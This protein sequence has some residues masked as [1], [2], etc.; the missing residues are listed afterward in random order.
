MAGGR[1]YTIVEVLYPYSAAEPNQISLHPHEKITVLEKDKS[2][3]WIGKR[4]NDDVGIFPSTYV[5]VVEDRLKF[6]RPKELKQL[7]LSSGSAQA[8][9]ARR[10]S[11]DDK[12]K[13]WRH[14]LGLDSD[15]DADTDAKDGKEPEKL[16]KARAEVA[17][18]RKHLDVVS[19][20]NTKL[21][22]YGL[23]LE[24]EKEQLAAET[25]TIRQ[26]LPVLKKQLAAAHE[27]ERRLVLELDDWKSMS[28]SGSER[29]PPR[30]YRDEPDA[31]LE[32]WLEAAV[33]DRL[34]D[35]TDAISMLKSDND[36]LKRKLFEAEKDLK[37]QDDDDDLDTP[38]LSDNVPAKRQKKP[39]AEAETS[40]P[41]PGER[42]DK[43]DVVCLAADTANN[44]ASGCLKPTEHG[45]VVEDQGEDSPMPFRVRNAD[46]EDSWYTE[47]DLRVVSR[48]KR[49]MEKLQEGRASPASVGGR[50]SP[51]PSAS[52]GD[53]ESSKKLEDELKEKNKKLRKMEK[54]QQ[55]MEEDLDALEKY[56][57]KLEKKLDKLKKNP[58]KAA[59]PTPEGEADAGGDKAAPGSPA[60]VQEMRDYIAKLEKKN[61]KLADKVA[62]GGASSPSPPPEVA[63]EAPALPS[64][65]LPEEMDKLR[66]ELE[67]LRREAS[68]EK[69]LMQKEMGGQ[70]AGLEM[71]LAEARAALHE[72]GEKETVHLKEME[73]TKA[74]LE[75]AEQAKVQLSQQYEESKVLADEARA[76]KEEAE[77]MMSNW[78]EEKQK[79]EEKLD[80]TLKRLEQNDEEL[81][82][83]NARYKKEEQRRRVLYNQLMELKGNIRVFCRIRLVADEPPECVTLEDD[84]T[85]R[86][87]DP[88]SGK[89]TPFEFDKC[90]D[91]D[92]MQSD[93]F[94]EA[95]GLA[96]SVLDGYNVC[97]FA[98]GQTGSG[99]TY[100]MEGPKDNR[101]VNFRT[102]S[103][104]FRLAMEREA[105]YAYT[106]SVS[107]LEVYNDKIF[108]LQNKR[109]QVKVTPGVKGGDGV[110]IVPL[111]KTRVT[112][113]DQVI[114]AL[115]EAYTNRKVGG[116]SMNE[117]SSRS[118][119]VLTVWIEAKNVSTGQMFTGKLHLVDLAGSERLA[120]SEVTG[121]QKVESVHI[122]KSL[123]QLGLCINSLANKK[124]HIPFR[125]SQLTTL[126]QDSLGGNCKCL[127]FAN[128][129]PK[130]SNVP[131][132]IST[133]N[134][135]TG[136]KKVEL[137]KASKNVK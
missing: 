117:H 22:E 25:G 107:V 84:M 75:A 31:A 72:S 3:W 126:L 133:L 71:E 74:S 70:K 81:K 108:D 94:E 49:K 79:F 95:K 23:R 136:A 48:G 85:V 33:H 29:P 122:N 121:D 127:M 26:Q 82:V 87:K 9:G 99:K 64:G 53:G 45:T 106:L 132:T 50:A 119:C 30:E 77:K 21:N 36:K 89:I 98:Y 68:Q 90:F 137:G 83:A 17:K 128:I 51:A 8:G 4:S 55:L 57:A 112:D 43:H 91:Q 93:V 88:Q 37:R 101:G 44:Y 76:K 27:K 113:A 134:F 38:D 47:T 18:L 7:P 46:G 16:A 5:R 12:A 105:E 41:Q 67:V 109:I 60:E 114:S 73:A 103:E 100:T 123:T 56:N 120:K 116:T 80:T 28:E 34:R 115:E 96:V 6:N 129:S 20:E 58:E 1:E 124:D 10:S 61:R 86:I 15:S 19:A 110:S 24:K 59:S 104:L 62:A 125:N 130:T 35:A 135:A 97:I 2:G 11:E 13:Q 52:G 65:V 39:A 78:A 32:R 40:D 42:P 63:G 102:V 14:E 118:H 111:E 66:E 69:E 54:R 131:E 92:S